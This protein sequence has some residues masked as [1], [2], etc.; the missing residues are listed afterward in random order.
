MRE[1]GAK[2]RTITLTAVNALVRGL[3]LAMRVLLSRLLGAEIMGIMEL[4]SGV[5][6]LAITPL[7]SGL[8]LAVSRLTAKARAG[9]EHGPLYAA[10]RLARLGALWLMPTLVLLSPLIARLSGDMRVLP[11]LW[12]SAPCVL[13]LGYSAAYN[14]YCYGIERSAVPAMSELIEQVVRFA[15]AVGLSM[16]LSRLTAAWA[17]AVPVFATMAAELMG[18]WYVIR[19]LRVPL[20]AP[21]DE[22]AIRSRL[23]RLSAPTTATRLINTALRSVTAMMIP[24]RL[25]A[26]GLSA[27]EAMARLGMLNGMA[28]PLVMLPCI[29]TAALS[30]VLMPRLSRLE[31]DRAALASLLRRMRV[32][33]LAV[34]ALC[35]VL[36]YMA[37]PFLAVRVYR[38]AELGAL[39]RVASPLVALSA[40]THTTT[41]AIAGLGRQKRAMSGALAGSAVSLLLTWTLTAMPSMRLHGALLAMYAGQIVVWGWNARILRDAL[42]GPGA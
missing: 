21:P 35:G 18:L 11:S 27:P 41:G 24:A 26:S 7:T 23:V 14:G 8:P 3:G 34:G 12:L 31:N 38:A 1:G 25:Q 33:A 17:A 37:A 28:M 16:A 15:L 20:S 42:R 19:T 5:H 13:I 10:L 40:I 2:R 6:M 30:M 4:A 9:E 22:K 36:L 32:S 39:L 29:F